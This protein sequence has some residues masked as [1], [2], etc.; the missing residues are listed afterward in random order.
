M[1]KLI[2]L[3]LALSIVSVFSG[4]MNNERPDA[5]ATSTEDA[6]E[7]DTDTVSATR[8]SG[9]TDNDGGVQVWTVKSNYIDGDPKELLR[10][11][12]ATISDIINSGNWIDDVTKCASDCVI[13]TADGDVFY[14]HSACG[15]FNDTKNSRS[16]STTEEE[17]AVVNGILRQYVELE[18]DSILD[19]SASRA[20]AINTALTPAAKLKVSVGANSRI[21]TEKTSEITAEEA[22]MIM[23]IIENGDWNKGGTADCANDCK[24][25]VNGETYYYHSDCGTLNDTLNNRCLTVTEAEKESINGVL[26]QYI[27]LGFVQPAQ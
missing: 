24:L 10:E 7:I 13:T 22:E 27:T 16:R 15:T 11:E 8:T 3:V 4:C 26:G 1:K 9:E 23:T 17:L 21:G 2:A 12:T 18:S 20:P 6:L 25:T 19:G 14:Y 5:P